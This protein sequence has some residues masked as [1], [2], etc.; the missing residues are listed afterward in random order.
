MQMKT[1]KRFAEAW[2]AAWNRRDVD[3]VLA[4]DADE[5]QFVSSV[6]VNIVGRPVLRDKREFA[7]YW[8]AA[9][10]RIASSSSGSISRMGRTVARA[11][12]GL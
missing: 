6:A 4:H 2:V 10:G 7:D 1:M 9:L 5:T 12:R 8:R 3:A 11:E